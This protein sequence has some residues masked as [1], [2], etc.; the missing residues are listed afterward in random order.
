M[1]NETQEFEDIN[2][3]VEIAKAL[4]ISTATT[5]GVCAGF[6]VIGYAYSKFEELKKA[7]Q[8]KKIAKNKN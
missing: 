8:A 1:D 4:A 7:R 6:L 2:F 3:G 5:V